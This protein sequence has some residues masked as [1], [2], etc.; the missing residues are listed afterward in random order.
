MSRTQ[1]ESDRRDTPNRRPSTSTQ[2]ARQ[3]VEGSRF[4]EGITQRSDQKL[5]QQRVTWSSGRRLD[6][7]IS[8]N[9]AELSVFGIHGRGL[10]AVLAACA[11]VLAY[12]T[13]KYLY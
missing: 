13:L 5:T 11:V 4:T 2:T 9:L 3:E 6:Q 12:L 7:I 1:Q 10:V 8:G